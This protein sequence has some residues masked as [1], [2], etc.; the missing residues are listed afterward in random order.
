MV[1]LKNLKELTK[2]FKVL[3][4]ED[5]SSIRLSTSQYLSKFFSKVVTAKDGIE[6]LEAYENFKFDIV[7]TD[8]AMPRMSGLEMIKGI[9]ETDGNQAILITT[10]YN[11]SKHMIEAIRL[12]VDGY[13]IKPIDFDQLN[14]ELYKIAEK[15]KKFQENV[16]YKIHLEQMVETKTSALNEMMISQRD[17]YEKT[18]LSMIEMI[19]SRDTYT[20]GHSKRVAHYCQIIAQ[21]MGYSE[22]ECKKIYQAGILH[23]IGKIATPDAILLNPKT[24]NNLEY[25]LIKEHV[26][27]SFQV[28]NNIPMFHDLAEIIYSHHERFDGKG[29]PF[30][31]SGNDINPFSRIMIVA[32][33]FDAITTNRIYKPKKEVSEAIEELIKLKSIQFHPEV[34]DKAVI[35]L[36]DIKLDSNINQLPKSNLEAERF[37]YFYRDNVCNVYNQNY[38]DAVLINNKIEKKFKY[39]DIFYL[40]NFSSYNKI[41]GWGRGNKLLGSFAETLK[42]HFKDSP[43]FR[44]H[45]DDFV[46]MSL[47]K[48]EQSSLKTLLDEIIKNSGIKYSIKHLDL[49]ETEINTADQLETI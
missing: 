29:Y 15:L 20:A 41:Y 22:I 30:G 31:L 2:N 44:L 49:S 36:R 5:N 39:M 13:I 16:E 11:S 27:V 7:I 18:L 42:E 9:K 26:K 1:K 10:A 6:G 40:E 21:E 38:L 14:N 19:E 12:G 32:D 24:L 4:V 28:L 48:D 33:A 17:N 3:Y 35:A 23:D 8:L 46:V 45:G 25:Q 43:V 37:A 47:Q 34:V